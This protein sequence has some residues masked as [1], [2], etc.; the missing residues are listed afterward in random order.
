MTTH[1]SILAWKIQ[2]TEN[3]VGY[4]PQGCE[5]LDTTEQLSKITSTCT[6]LGKLLQTLAPCLIATKPCLGL[7]TLVFTNTKWKLIHVDRVVHVL[8]F[9][10][11][12]IHQILTII[13]RTR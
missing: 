4:S 6:Q 1:S 3:L 11:H 9:D 7:A 8:C 13:L 10:M 12:F 2:Q 5:A